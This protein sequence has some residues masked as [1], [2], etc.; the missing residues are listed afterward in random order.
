M[1]FAIIHDFSLFLN[2]IEMKSYPMYSSFFSFWQH[3]G[4][5]ETLGP[6]PGIEPMPPALEAW[7]L[8][9]WTTR[10]VPPQ[11][12]LYVWLI[13]LDKTSFI[14]EGPPSESGIRVPAFISSLVLLLLHVFVTWIYHHLFLL[15]LIYRLW[16]PF[17]GYYE[18]S[19]FEHFCTCPFVNIVTIL[20]TNFS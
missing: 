9:H 5:C 1:N 11:C 17:F 13:L 6:R 18:W 2:F 16:F 3:C 14:S 7:S 12:T 19:C 15:S 20:Y 8:N 4:A 10:E